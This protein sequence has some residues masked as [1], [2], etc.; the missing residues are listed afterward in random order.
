ML[1]RDGL[2]V[3]EKPVWIVLALDRDQT[4]IIIAPIG[5]REILLMPT[6]IVLVGMPVAEGRVHFHELVE[7]TLE[8][9]FFLRRAPEQTEERVHQ[10]VTMDEGIGALAHAVDLE[11]TFSNYT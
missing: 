2:L 7:E 11:I 10:H 4:R 8:L 6:R 3:A 1:Q 9:A 5:V